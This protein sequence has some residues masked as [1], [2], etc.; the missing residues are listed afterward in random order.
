MKRGSHFLRPGVAIDTARETKKSKSDDEANGA[1]SLLRFFLSATRDVEN[2]CGAHLHDF[3]T[4]AKLIAV[5][6]GLSTKNSLL[7]R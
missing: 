4:N 5:R 3:E 2:L 1:P 6:R 7:A